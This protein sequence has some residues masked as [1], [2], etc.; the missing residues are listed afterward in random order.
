MMTRE[1][2]SILE[3]IS[4]RNLRMF[5]LT[6]Y[7]RDIAEVIINLTFAKQR[8]SVV[9]RNLEGFVRLTGIDKADVS[10]TI[11]MLRAYGS[12]QRTGPAW[13]REYSFVP[14][15]RYWSER[16]PR[17]D[18][19]LAI[20]WER[21]IEQDTQLSAAGADPS[22]QARLELP[23][24]PPG[25]DEGMALAAREDAL[26]PGAVGD[27]PIGDSPTEGGVGDSPISSGALIVPARMRGGDVLQYVNTQYVS[28]YVPVGDSPKA[29]ESGRRF[30]DPER[31][32]VFD[33]VEKLASTSERDL[34]D[35]RR[36]RPNWIRRVRDNP[37]I[38]KEAAGE[39]R[40][41]EM[42][43]GNKRHRPVLAALF[44]ECNKIAKRL[45]V[46]TF[47]LW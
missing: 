12:V 43:P 10:T 2:Y 9:I 20:Q 7:E 36:N 31:N 3:A 1:E 37:R 28:Q 26:A 8:D 39:V 5:R 14:S 19:E 45:G 27:S 21:Q 17:F 30:N 44:C 16:T 41:R 29:G 40:L 38:V 34:A 15:A 11:K 33:I 18:V 47:R 35:L 6:S 46:T 32:Y 42:N 25:L 22:R 13:A 24:E 4:R 23:A